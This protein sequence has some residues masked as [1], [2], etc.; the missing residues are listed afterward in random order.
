MVFGTGVD[1]EREVDR[2]QDA[3]GLLGKIIQFQTPL[4][5]QGKL[6]A[7]PQKSPVS[8]TS[9]VF[10]F[11]LGKTLCL[12]RTFETEPVSNVLARQSVLP[13]GKRKTLLVLETG[14]FCGM[15]QHRQDVR[16]GTR[17]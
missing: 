15:A 4:S 8:N 14:D 3:P 6:R 5:I 11:P 17:R 7:M 9:K 12:A 13:S 2:V 1:S 10:L 16:D